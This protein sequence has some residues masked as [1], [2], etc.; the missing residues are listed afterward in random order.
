[1]L[2]HNGVYYLKGVV[3]RIGSGKL[4][5]VEKRVDIVSRLDHGDLLQWL[6]RT[7]RSFNEAA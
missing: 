1:M 6:R 4:K 2:R 5:G 3:S 7:M